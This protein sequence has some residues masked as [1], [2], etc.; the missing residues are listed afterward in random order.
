VVKIATEEF[1]R[2]KSPSAHKIPAGLMQAG[3]ELLRSE[4]H[5]LI[6]SVRDKKELP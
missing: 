6:K 1:K 3:G 5:K 2:F 4:M